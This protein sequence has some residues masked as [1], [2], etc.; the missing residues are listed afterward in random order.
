[1]SKYKRLFFLIAAGV[2]KYLHF[3]F[4]RHTLLIKYLLERCDKCFLGVLDEV[5]RLFQG[6]LEIMD[7]V[8]FE[9]RIY[10]GFCDVWRQDLCYAWGTYSEDSLSL[11][12]YGSILVLMFFTRQCK[13]CVWA[14]LPDHLVKKHIKMD[15]EAASLL[16]LCCPLG[17]GH[18]FIIIIFHYLFKSWL[19]LHGFLLF[20]IC[21][22]K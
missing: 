21:T 19:W 14:D 6:M 17:S 7:T 15:S 22:K 20:Y 1:M 3:S 5:L 11:L 18:T 8:I 2:H 10:N 13:D 9:D 16:H 4:I 12:K